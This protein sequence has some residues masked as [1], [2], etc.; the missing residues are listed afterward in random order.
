MSKLGAL[1]DPRV[2]QSSINTGLFSMDQL[3]SLGIDFD[4]ILKNPEDDNELMPPLVND[5]PSPTQPER[6]KSKRGKKVRKSAAS[7]KNSEIISNPEESLTLTSFK[8]YRKQKKSDSS[9]NSST[10]C[11]IYSQ[12]FNQITMQYD[13]F[14]YTFQKRKSAPKKIYFISKLINLSTIPERNVLAVVMRFENKA[15]SVLGSIILPS[16]STLLLSKI[17]K[18]KKVL[19][20][21][22]K[23]F[24]GQLKHIQTSITTEV[25][26]LF[27]IPQNACIIRIIGRNTETDTYE[28]IS[29][30][31]PDYS[32]LKYELTMTTTKDARNSAPIIEF[33]QGI[34][35]GIRLPQEYPFIIE[36]NNEMFEITEEGRIKFANLKSIKEDVYTIVVTLF[37]NAGYYCISSTEAKGDE[38]FTLEVANGEGL[39]KT[40]DAFVF[41]NGKISRKSKEN[42]SITQNKYI[43]GMI[44]IKI[45]HINDEGLSEVVDTLFAGVDASS[46][47]LKAR[48][49][50]D[51]S[52]IKYSIPIPITLLGPRRK[53]KTKKSKST[54]Q[55]K[56]SKQIESTY[57]SYASSGSD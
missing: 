43:P 15:F 9:D 49:A 47:Q 19:V 23:N 57:D 31:L 30:L 34:E 18:K 39:M 36:K 42:R 13:T 28:V 46:I 26:L 5:L 10:S 32:P 7:I 29:S 40:L 22:I 54:K 1:S 27:H 17:G 55:S 12:S 38:Y 35:A 6:S 41:R 45:I 16:Q 20:D 25:P 53:Y 48:S 51:Q 44:L 52:K 2:T 4:K 33:E 14:Q 56:P 8:N 21:D 3:K 24:D 11:I 50:L 37:N